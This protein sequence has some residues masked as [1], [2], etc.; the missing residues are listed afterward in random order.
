MGDLRVYL[1]DT[2]IPKG[3]RI[4]VDADLETLGI[5]K[6]VNIQSNIASQLVEVKNADLTNPKNDLSRLEDS[7]NEKSDE[8][9][10]FNN[11]TSFNLD[12]A[13]YGVIKKLPNII[14]EQNGKVTTFFRKLSLEE[15]WVLYD[16]EAGNVTDKLFGMAVDIGTTTI[17]GYLIYIKTGEI[18][19]VSA[20]LNP[21]IMIGEDVISRIS[22]IV[23]NK[24]IERAKQLIIKAINQIMEDCCY[25]ANISISEIRDIAIVGNTAMHH[26]VFGIPS[27]F[28]AI[29]PYTP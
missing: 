20:L 24:A 10:I 17:V 5:N 4:L 16:I 14:R 23:K 27:E 6:N 25:K 7:I 29:S 19:A 15:P 11:P 18:G 1:T 8:F 12:N 26:M 28:L 2:L 9:R 3:P 21:Q 22:Y 13:L